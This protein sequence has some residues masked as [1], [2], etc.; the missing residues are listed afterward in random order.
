MCVRWVLIHVF[1]GRKVTWITS[2][3]DNQPSQLLLIYPKKE[4]WTKIFRFYRPTL[5]TSSNRT[6]KP[7]VVSP[8]LTFSFLGCGNHQRWIVVVVPRRRQVQEIQIYIFRTR[9]R[10]IRQ[11]TAHHW[12]QRRAPLLELHSP[13]SGR[14]YGGHQR[15]C[16]VPLDDRKGNQALSYVFPFLAWW[17]TRDF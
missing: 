5:R 14:H 10:L 8:Y 7:R 1:V 13:R 6:N 17:L 16:C 15:S 2:G 11:S 12:Q 4:T 9:H 3:Q